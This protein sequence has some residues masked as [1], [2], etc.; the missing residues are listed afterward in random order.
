[1]A[2]NPTKLEY[3]RVKE[4]IERATLKK[5]IALILEKEAS[6]G[7]FFAYPI[8][9]LTEDGR[10]NWASK[11]EESMGLF[12][13]KYNNMQDFFKQILGREKYQT[14]VAE[15]LDLDRG[16]YAF[17]SMITRNGSADYFEQ[18]L[19]AKVTRNE[20]S[21]EDVL[22]LVK[23]QIRL[24]NFVGLPHNISLTTEEW[25]EFLL[26]AFSNRYKNE[27]AEI[28]FEENPLLNSD[29]ESEINNVS[30]MFDSNDIKSEEGADNLEEQRRLLIAVIDNL[31]TTGNFASL[32]IR[33]AGKEDFINQLL[34]EKIKT[35]VRN[36]DGRVDIEKTYQEFISRIN[37]L[38]ISDSFDD[39]CELIMLSRQILNKYTKDIEILQNGVVSLHIN[40]DTNRIKRS[41]EEYIKKQAEAIIEDI[42]DTL[43]DQDTMGNIAFW[44]GKE[45][46][47]I[48][49]AIKN[50][51]KIRTKWKRDFHNEYNKG[52]SAIVAAAEKLI[53]EEAYDYK[54]KQ[55]HGCLN[56]IEIGNV[57]RR[58]KDKELSDKEKSDVKKELKQYFFANQM[59]VDKVVESEYDWKYKLSEISDE[60]HD[61]PRG[62]DN[63]N[64]YVPF[65]IL[66]DTYLK[67]IKE[68]PKNTIEDF[69]QD[70]LKLKTEYSRG[71]YKEFCKTMEMRVAEIK[72][73]D[74]KVDSDV[75]LVSMAKFFE[76]KQK[77]Y[78]LKSLNSMQL[79]NAQ[80]KMHFC[81]TQK[82]GNERENGTVNIGI[83]GYVE[84]FGVHF[85]NNSPEKRIVPSI[86]TS[87]NVI[88]NAYESENGKVY[89]P[90]LKLTQTQKEEFKRLYGYISQIE[91][92]DSNNQ[93]EASLS[94]AEKN[95]Y[96]IL[97]SMY[98]KSNVAIRENEEIGPINP[99][100]KV[101][102]K[103]RKKYNANAIL[104]NDYNAIK[105]QVSLGAGLEYYK[106]AFFLE[107]VQEN[108]QENTQEEK[109]QESTQVIELRQQLANEKRQ[110][111]ELRREIAELKSREETTT[112]RELR[113]QLAEARNIIQTQAAR[114]RE[115]ENSSN[116][117]RNDKTIRHK[118]I[119]I[120]DIFKMIK[121]S[122]ISKRIFKNA[123]NE[124]PSGEEPE[125]EDRD[126]NI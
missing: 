73:M 104:I 36:D 69:M 112:E 40:K 82:E 25:D 57:L 21:K 56:P 63:D 53:S 84:L 24:K 16:A 31:H 100:D 28:E 117:Q 65:P 51:S 78:N 125:P 71:I 109:E 95:K 108:V 38:N 26:D 77:V 79:Y 2:E 60:Y 102:A 92:N 42:L 10:K 118:K 98:E 87:P 35:T 107:R 43:F 5:K 115:F 81:G 30:P 41:A 70:A 126:N 4:N 27:L 33:T 54:G 113:Q 59:Q 90:F 45:V 103:I 75:L 123:I 72:G 94:E 124:L 91:R 55:I 68:N 106:A 19:A 39:R 120:K 22:R 67:Y 64:S 46:T 23:E 32:A 119:E 93:F 114:I 97:K 12:Y 7:V 15:F 58:I 99:D 8:E 14:V 76:R 13:F 110:N 17:D 48:R 116:T 86:L 88:N 85:E 3:E 44:D 80:H 18:F 61:L 34:D 105:L 121:N 83:D 29:I 96:N 122:G 9:R 1:M 89:I 20:I 66:M 47:G 101:D 74:L 50:E 6:R 49:G 52:V 62:N 111:E 37:S 11:I